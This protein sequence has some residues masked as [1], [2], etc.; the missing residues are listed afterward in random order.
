[1]FATIKLVFCHDKLTFV[2]TN[3]FVVTK[4]VF[5]IVTKVLS[6]K[7]FVTTKVLSWQLSK[8]TFVTTK[9]I[10]AAAPAND[11]IHTKGNKKMC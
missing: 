9:M 6:R 2:M 3:V 8:H 10:L 11:I 1:M 7:Y 4:H 5:L